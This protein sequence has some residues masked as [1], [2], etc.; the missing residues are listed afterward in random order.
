MRRRTAVVFALAAAVALTGAAF[1]SMSALSTEPRG[2]DADPSLSHLSEEEKAA[3]D[4]FLVDE[5][6]RVM[7]GE[8]SDPSISPG[9]GMTDGGEGYIVRVYAGADAAP[10]EKAV[11]GRFPEVQVLA[12]H[13]TPEA[14][15]E[16][17]AAIGSVPIAE[18]EAI[19]FD[20]DAATD[21]FRV[22][23]TVP[24]ETMN[25]HLAS[26][27]GGFSYELAVRGEAGR[28]SRTSDPV[29]H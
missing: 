21:T 18:G 12:S 22:S 26:F 9:V 25:K 20:F 15:R 29:P 8:L 24:A 28:L 2:H 23:G 19:G 10:I 13:F 3:D 27:E 5:A 11:E 1:V 16:L 7:I 17:E 14:F 4:A 6:R